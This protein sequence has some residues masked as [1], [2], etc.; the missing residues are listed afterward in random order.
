MFNLHYSGEHTVS[1]V[2]LSL[3]VD[4]SASLLTLLQANT[5]ALVESKN[6][7]ITARKK[8]LAINNNSYKKYDQISYTNKTEILSKLLVTCLYFVSG[9]D[10]AVNNNTTTSMS[11]LSSEPN[12]H[13]SFVI[14]LQSQAVGMIVSGIDIWAVDGDN[15][16]YWIEC[17]LIK[18]YTTLFDTTTTTTNTNTSVLLVVVSTDA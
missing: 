18:K 3:I 10:G 2:D 4:V 14:S 6:N 12:K 16:L 5:T 7:A 11:K 17:L 13:E 9:C 15:K 8:T 1:A